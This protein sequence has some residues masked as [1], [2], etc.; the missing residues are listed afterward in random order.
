MVFKNLSHQ[1]NTGL[2]RDIRKANQTAMAAAL[3]ENQ[4]AKVLVHRHEDSLLG[5]GP[6]KDRSVAGIGAAVLGFHD[7]MSQGP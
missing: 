7:I 2:S 1:P 3:K 5:G 6:G 4:V